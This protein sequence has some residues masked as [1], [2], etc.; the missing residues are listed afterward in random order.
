M[1]IRVVKR[2]SL[3][4]LSEWLKGQF[5]MVITVDKMTQFRMVIR[6][7][8]RGSLGWLIAWLKRGNLAW[9]LGW[10]KGAV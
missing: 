4:W 9:L 6:V 3:G 5:R 8:K 7:V 10:L 1:V 2:G